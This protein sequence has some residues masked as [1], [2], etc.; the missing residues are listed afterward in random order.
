ISATQLPSYIKQVKQAYFL[1]E[2]FLGPIF[3]L[4]ITFLAPLFWLFFWL[5]LL[6]VAVPPP[7]VRLPG[8][9]V[10]KSS[11]VNTVSAGKTNCPSESS[12]KFWIMF[13]SCTFSLYKV[14]YAIFM[15]LAIDKA[16][17]S[18]FSGVDMANVFSIIR[19]PVCP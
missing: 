3:F 19:S 12:A 14:M 7:F 8:G 4:T 9:G 13:S 2:P 11:L 5:L 18:L 1:N 10:L 16:I 15:K 17:R 6:L